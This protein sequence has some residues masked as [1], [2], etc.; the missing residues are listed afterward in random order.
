MGD[1]LWIA[2]CSFQDKVS[3]VLQALEVFPC[4]EII[5]RSSPDE[6]LVYEGDIYQ[7][8]GYQP[9]WATQTPPVVYVGANKRQMTHMATRIADGLMLTAWASGAEAIDLDLGPIQAALAERMPFILT[10]LSQAAG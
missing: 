1:S 7:V 2:H 5:K 3:L 8:R 9:R 10:D 4:V 6:P